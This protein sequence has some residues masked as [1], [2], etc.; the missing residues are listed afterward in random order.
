V[1]VE[2]RGLGTGGGSGGPS[3]STLEREYIWMNGVPVATIEGG[4]TY[5]VRTDHIGRPVFATD[6][7]TSGGGGGG[8]SILNRAGFAGG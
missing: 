1:T 3:T 2:I 6:G 4:T 7:T 5:Y 8:G